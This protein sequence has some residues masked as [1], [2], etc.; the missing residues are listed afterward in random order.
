M[1]QRLKLIRDE[2]IGEYFWNSNRTNDWPSASLQ[3]YLN[4]G[5]YWINDLDDDAKDM[6]DNTLWY[7]GGI[8]DYLNGGT[9]FLND[10]YSKERGLEV[11]NGRK[12]SWIGKIGLIYPSDYGYA[13]SGNEET[14]RNA[15]LNSD[16]FTWVNNACSNSDW[17][18]ISK[19]QWTIT[20][21]LD[22]Y[23]VFIILGYGPVG[24]FGA[25]NQY[26]VK[27]VTFV[28]STVKI[29]DGDGSSVNPY[30]LES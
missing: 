24:S 9:G 17:L 27:P 22:A 21:S 18:F 1:E 8:R 25:S 5:D 10:I 4:S 26:E 6:I 30:I 16:T 28:K 11:Y 3:S 19:E 2:S 23:N 14:D 20:P 12:T 29:V 7:L 13:A 15:C